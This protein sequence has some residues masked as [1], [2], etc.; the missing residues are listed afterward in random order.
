MITHSP[1]KGWWVTP[2]KLQK[3]GGL[4]SCSQRLY[5]ARRMSRDWSKVTCKK[6][7]AEHA[8][9]LLGSLP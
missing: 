7:K 2:K 1:R 5:T 4:T 3:R 6:C 9:Q 8:L